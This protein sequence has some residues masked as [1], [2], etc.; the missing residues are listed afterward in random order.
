MKKENE[1]KVKFS[2]VSANE[3]LSRIIVTGF[4]MPYYPTV[5]ELADIKTAVSEAVTN[6]IVHAYKSDETKFIT[7]SANVKANGVFTVSIKDTGCGIPD[8]HKAMEPLFTTDA[9]N[10]RSGMGF[11]IMQTFSDKLKVSS[12]VGRGTKVTMIKKLSEYKK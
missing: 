9:E 5:E 6:A 7:L 8:I 11:S 2:A 12:R 4:L 3:A 1:I 10:E